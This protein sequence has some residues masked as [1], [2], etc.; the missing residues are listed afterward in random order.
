MK[1]EK[2]GFSLP[3]ETIIVLLIIIGVLIIA[4]LLIKVS[5][6]SISSSWEYIK[7]L[8]RFK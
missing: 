3:I 4:Y 2:R 8:M 6:G 5:G 7:N 1:K